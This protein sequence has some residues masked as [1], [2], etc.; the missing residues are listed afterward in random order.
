MFDAARSVDSRRRYCRAAQRTCLSG[1]APSPE[2]GN[3]RAASAPAMPVFLSK[4]RPSLGAHFPAS[5]TRVGGVPGAAAPFPS[6]P[7]PLQLP[8]PL[9]LPAAAAPASGTARAARSS[10][11]ELSVRSCSAYTSKMALCSAPRRSVV[12][13]PASACAMSPDTR[14]YSWF[15]VRQEACRGT[16][17]SR[18]MAVLGHCFA[19]SRKNAAPRARSPFPSRMSNVSNARHHRSTACSDGA[20]PPNA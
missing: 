20:T 14:V 19:S 13:P 12:G 3:S 15:R 11:A 4:E 8:L 10:T 6:A 17:C 5:V 18:E 9:P 16:S 2:Y 7:L 1:G